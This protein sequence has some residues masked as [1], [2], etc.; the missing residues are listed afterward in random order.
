MFSIQAVITLKGEAEEYSKAQDA[1]VQ[2]L[3]NS[4]AVREA[5]YGIAEIGGKQIAVA[6]VGWD[7]VE[8][9][10]IPFDGKIRERN[11]ARERECA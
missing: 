7:S 5:R 9:Y 10:G 6:F 11:S 2:E 3:R 1:A 8:V 4:S